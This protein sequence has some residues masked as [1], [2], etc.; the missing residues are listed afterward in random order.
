VRPWHCAHLETELHH[1][2]Q[3]L[4]Q[5]GVAR[6]SGKQRARV[7]Q[8]VE[9]CW[10]LHGVCVVVHRCPWLHASPAQLPSEALGI[11]PTVKERL[12][13]PPSDREHIANT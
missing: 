9:T 3:E 8:V 1:L 5:D 6:V 12:A 4:E 2:S 13:A 10:R 11:P 7:S